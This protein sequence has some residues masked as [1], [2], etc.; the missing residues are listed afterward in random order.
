M[1]NAFEE[2]PINTVGIIG[3]NVKLNCTLSD[4][5]FSLYWRN[6]D[7]YNVYEKGTGILQVFE[8]QYVVEEYGNSYNLVVLNAEVDDAGRY[9]CYCATMSSSALAEI[10][11]LGK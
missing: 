8:G 3:Q 2:L 5:A 11:L 7:G 6:P 1:Q 4:G 10:I 9:D